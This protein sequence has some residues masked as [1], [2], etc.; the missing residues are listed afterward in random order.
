MNIFLFHKIF[1]NLLT[2]RAAS[3]STG[4]SHSFYHPVQ[5]KGTTNPENGFSVAECY[6]HVMEY[7][8]EGNVARRFY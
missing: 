8:F 7:A 1:R 2:R 5:G 6:S 3:E 4:N